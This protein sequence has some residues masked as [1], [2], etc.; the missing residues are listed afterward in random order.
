M[1]LLFVFKNVTINLYRPPQPGRYDE[2][3]RHKKELQH[4]KCRSVCDNFK[5][6]FFYAYPLLILFSSLF[7][8]Y[9]SSPQITQ[10]TSAAA[11]KASR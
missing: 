3:P 1:A 8:R 7:I 2:Y 6:V 10:Y 9:V 5:I 11:T 4:Y